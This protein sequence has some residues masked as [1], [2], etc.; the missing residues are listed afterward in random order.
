M[1]YNEK[2]KLTVEKVKRFSYGVRLLE[3]ETGRRWRV[4]GKPKTWKRTPGRVEVG[5]QY[6]LYTWDRLTQDNLD[7]FVIESPEGMDAHTSKPIWSESH[8]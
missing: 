1:L 3:K 7:D 4:N 8:D 5:I 6:G 2:Q